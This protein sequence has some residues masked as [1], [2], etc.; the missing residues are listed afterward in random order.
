MK[1]FVDSNIPMY[2]AGSAHPNRG[3]ASRFL[4][5]AVG[6]DF[7]LCTS[8]EVLQ[9]ILYRYVSLERLDLAE[10]VR[11]RPEDMARLNLAI[12]FDPV[13]SKELWLGALTDAEAFARSGPT[14]RRAASTTLRSW[15][16]S[17]RPTARGTSPARGWSRTLVHPAVCSRGWRMLPPSRS[18]CQWAKSGSREG[19]SPCRYPRQPR[20]GRRSGSACPLP[21]AWR[22]RLLRR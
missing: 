20:R 22:Q 6:E 16:A 10:Q 14:T 3:P 9:E 4:E 17:P 7:D 13:T 15:T 8:T 18:S 19:R 5:G 21:R 1:V 2:V 12:P 11:H